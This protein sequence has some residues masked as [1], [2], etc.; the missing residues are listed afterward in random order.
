MSCVHP[1]FCSANA[2]IP[3]K[4]GSPHR[5]GAGDRSTT[6]F[7]KDSSTRWSGKERGSTIGFF[8]NLSVLFNLV[9]WSLT[10]CVGFVC[11]H[12]M[13]RS[14]LACVADD[15]ERARARAHT[16]AWLV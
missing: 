7:T 1:S 16:I 11:L 13:L 12:V 4:S 9:R 15:R 2:R 8:D 10:A 5:N 14:K 3:S 6:G